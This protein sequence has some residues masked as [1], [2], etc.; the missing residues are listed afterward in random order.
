MLA[1][2][3][4]I[5]FAGS[6]ADIKAS[7]YRQSVELGLSALVN[8]GSSKLSTSLW[9]EGVEVCG[10]LCQLT[11]ATERGGIEIIA[12][13]RFDKRTC[14]YGTAS[15]LLGTRAIAIARFLSNVGSPL[16]RSSLHWAAAL[17]P[18]PAQTQ[19]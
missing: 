11:G 1:A 12:I 9:Q 10:V 3:T 18:R 8:Q 2:S 17:V 14:A 13:E 19:G 5:A 6:P 7:A 15:P 4:S 16:L